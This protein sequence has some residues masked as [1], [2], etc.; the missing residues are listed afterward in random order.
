MTLKG[1]KDVNLGY[2]TEFSSVNG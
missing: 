1:V 2:S